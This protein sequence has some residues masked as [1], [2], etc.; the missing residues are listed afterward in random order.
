M[1]TSLTLSNL[2]SLVGK[3]IVWEA[4]AY[5]ANQGFHGY[6]CYG[7][8]EKITKVDLTARRPIVETEKVDTKSDNLTF[9][10]VDD[11]TL[12]GHSEGY[13][14]HRADGTNNVLSFSDADREVFYEVINE[15]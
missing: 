1:R 8:I 7:G 10:F 13:K 15:N 2:E 5:K 9:A 3:T 4:E 12:T 6:G 14:F 11:H